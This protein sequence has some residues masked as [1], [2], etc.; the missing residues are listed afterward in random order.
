MTK[1]YSF[2]YEHFLVLVFTFFLSL[3]DFQDT[4]GPQPT[5]WERYAQEEYDLLVAEE[6]AN[7]PTEGYVQVVRTYKTNILCVRVCVFTFLG[8]MVF[9]RPSNLFA[10]LESQHFSF[11]I[12]GSDIWWPFLFAL[13]VN[14][15]IFFADVSK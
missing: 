13:R 1:L 6:G 4:D 7:E 2:V 10:L 12:A 8:K 11:F 9:Q 3:K 14:V 5:D 15:A